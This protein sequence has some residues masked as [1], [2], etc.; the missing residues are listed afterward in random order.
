MLAKNVLLGVGITNETKE[1]ILEYIFK[2]LEKN[3]DPSFIVTPNPEILV[4]AHKHKSFR[5]ILNKADLAL[6]DGVGIILAGKFLG[7]PVKERLS[8]TDLMD[9][10]CKESAKKPITVGFLGGRQ[11]VAVRTADCLREKY[12]GLYIGF[13]AEEWDDKLPKLPKAPMLDVLFIAFGFPKQEEWMAARV[14]KIP[15][16]VM[17]GVG[18]AF[19][20]FSGRI[21][22]APRFVRSLGLEWL[23]R[24]IRQPWRIKRQLALIE[25]VI[26]L[27]K[28]RF[29]MSSST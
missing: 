25:F 14:G 20:Y 7:K 1:N 8:G 15:V 27:F 19:D 18:G 17:I 4:F 26:L 11:N 21:S 24:L 22:R 5:A 2:N 12:P 23:Y 6:P 3:A 28:E 16:Q 9:A 10:I 29:G 13:A